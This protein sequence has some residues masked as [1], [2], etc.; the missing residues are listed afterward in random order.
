MFVTF[1]WVSANAINAGGLCEKE[2]FF[3]KNLENK[4]L[5][6]FPG[7]PFF[8]GV[9]VARLKALLITPPRAVTLLSELSPRTFSCH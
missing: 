6:C 7:K 8:S 9:E 4:L 2:L 1:V 5:F 3:G